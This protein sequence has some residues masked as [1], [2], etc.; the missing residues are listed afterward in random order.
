MFEGMSDAVTI[1]PD[2]AKTLAVGSSTLGEIEVYIDS[3]RADIANREREHTD[4]LRVKDQEMKAAEEI[5]KQ[6]LNDVRRSRDEHSR[7]TRQLRVGIAAAMSCLNRGNRNTR[8]ARAVA[9]LR[10]LAREHSI[11]GKR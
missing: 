10:R 3:L 6:Q 8:N 5:T 1:G 11:I 4:D 2:T 7:T 9:A